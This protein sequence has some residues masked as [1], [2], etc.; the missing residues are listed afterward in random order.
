MTAE[1][2]PHSN[3][4]VGGRTELDQVQDE[5]DEAKRLLEDAHLEVQAAQCTVTGA[6]CQVGEAMEGMAKIKCPTEA[7][8]EPAD[9]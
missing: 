3:R 9:R 7:N 1:M 5:V 6:A 4:T 8:L 2:A